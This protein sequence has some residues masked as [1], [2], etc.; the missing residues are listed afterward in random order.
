MIIYGFTKITLGIQGDTNTGT[1]LPTS[2]Q[3]QMIPISKHSKYVFWEYCTIPI[4]PNGRLKPTTK[5]VAL[6]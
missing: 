1:H 6:A 4:H 3:A 5:Q 2:Y